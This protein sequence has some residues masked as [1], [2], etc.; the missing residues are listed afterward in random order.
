MIKVVFFGASVTKQGINHQ[1]LEMVGYVPNVIN[2]LSEKYG[3]SNIEF[4]QLGCGSVFFSDAGFI[5]FDEVIKLEPDIVV[6]DWHT[7]G[8][9]K[10]DDKR[11]GFVIKKLLSKNIKI[12]SLFLPFKR[13][14]GKEERLNVK[15]TR[16]YQ[17]NYSNFKILNF[18]KLKKPV[19][20]LDDCLR[21]E[22]HTTPYG[23]KVYGEIIS[24]A[25]DKF[26]KNELSCFD[27][28]EV[29]SPPNEINE[30]IVSK[31][32]IK[33][34][35]IVKDKLEIIIDNDIDNNEISV[36][37]DVISGPF[38]P[39]LRVFVD[40]KVLGRSIWDQWCYY[41]RTSLKRLTPVF[42]LPKGEFNIVIEV[43]EISPDYGE[44]KNVLLY[45]KTG[46]KLIIDGILVCLGAN[47]KKVNYN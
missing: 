18:F 16:Y 14:V 21:D 4:H 17:N 13:L 29:V 19:L 44:D 10:F 1:S 12:L 43:S 6:M 45:E 38:A 20:N 31:V 33:N 9:A 47:I 23:G 3:K 15:Q 28:G 37:A 36:L 2:I 42:L 24:D 46:K 5:H 27:D 39:R 26:I 32:N 22:V 11:Y 34:E 41:E 30:T 35:F 25:I 7:T 40:N 8:E